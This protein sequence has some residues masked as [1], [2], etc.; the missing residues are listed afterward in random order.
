MISFVNA[1]D[2]VK[3]TL[4]YSKA[5]LLTI[6]YSNTVTHSN[7]YLKG[8]KYFFFYKSR[9]GKSR[10]AIQKNHIYHTKQYQTFYRKIKY[11]LLNFRGVKNAYYQDFHG[12]CSFFS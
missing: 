5:L 8:D 9:C 1:Q 11:G 7:G 10:D 4:A 12:F 3:I 2:S 6:S